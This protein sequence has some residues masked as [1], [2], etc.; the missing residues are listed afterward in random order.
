MRRATLPALLG[1]VLLV[2]AAPGRGRA[3]EDAPDGRAALADQAAGRARDLA[4]RAVGGGAGD[5]LGREGGQGPH[6]PVAREDRRDASRA[7]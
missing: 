1:A 3:R 5:D 6:R 7:P 2:P 4:R